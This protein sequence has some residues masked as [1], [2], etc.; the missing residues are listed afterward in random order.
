MDKL[1]EEIAIEKEYIGKTLELLGETL[2]RS[3]MKLLSILMRINRCQ[4]VKL[5]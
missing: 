3:E 5:K 1:I 2:N 4:S